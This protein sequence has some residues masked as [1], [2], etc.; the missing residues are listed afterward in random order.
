MSKEIQYEKSF[1]SNEKS[2]YWSNKNINTERCILCH[3]VIN[4]VLIVI[5]VIIHLKVH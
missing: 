5:N 2:K 4:I 3:L 1:A